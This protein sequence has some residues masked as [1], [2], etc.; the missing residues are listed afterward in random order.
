MG[1]VRCV[2]HCSYIVSTHSCYMLRSYAGVLVTS[3][4]FIC[5]L[6]S[7]SQDINPKILRIKVNMTR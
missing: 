2:G 1:C 7:Y 3:L 4:L 5:S 6:S